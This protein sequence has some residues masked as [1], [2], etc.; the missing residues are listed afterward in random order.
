MHRQQRQKG[1]SVLE[2]ELEV[3][4]YF[5]NENIKMCAFIVVEQGL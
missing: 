2:R 5:C 3:N 1:L 4:R